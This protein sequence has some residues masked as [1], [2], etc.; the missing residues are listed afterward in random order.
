MI[1]LLS[2][3]VFTI[4]SASLCQCYSIHGNVITINQPP[5]LVQIGRRVDPS[6]GSSVG[7]RLQVTSKQLQHQRITQ[8]S[9]I[10]SEK[11]TEAS[12]IKQLARARMLKMLWLKKQ[13]EIREKRMKMC[14]RLLGK[15]ICENKGSFYIWERLLA[16]DILNG[17][18]VVKR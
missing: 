14:Q 9:K 18:V 6:S 7:E 12:M 10:L 13:K 5:E 8:L 11:I 4:C 2:I 15:A 17:K 3:F 1:K 16:Q